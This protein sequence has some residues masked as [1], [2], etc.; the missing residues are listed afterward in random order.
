[1][2]KK[3]SIQIEGLDKIRKKFGSIPVDLAEEVDAELLAGAVDFEGRAA[4]DAPNDLSGLGQG[5]KAV[6]VGEMHSEV[7]SGAP[8]SAYV[9]FGTITKVN[10]PADLTEFALQFKGK[11]IRKT[12]GVTP[13][14]FFFKQRK[15]VM[16]ALMKNLGPAIKRALEK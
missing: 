15:P 4:A 11:G 7:V 8:Y 9:E 12:G 14:P 3:I 10:V 5:I 16:D 6:H 1:M 13:Q 2:G